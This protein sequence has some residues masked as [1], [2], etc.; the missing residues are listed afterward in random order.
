M[1]RPGSARRRQVEQKE[2]RAGVNHLGPRV[3]RLRG[4]TEADSRWSSRWSMR[5]ICW[6][7]QNRPL[8]GRGP[9]VDRL[10]VQFMADAPQRLHGWLRA[11]KATPTSPFI[12]INWSISYTR[13][14]YSLLSTRATLLYIKASQVPQKRDQA[15][16][17]YSCAFSDSALWESLRQRV[18]YL[19]WSFERGV[20]SPIHCKARKSPLSLWLALRRLRSFV[21]KEEGKLTGLG[22]LSLV[23]SSTGIRF[24]VNWTSVK[25]ITRVT[26]LYCLRFVCLLAL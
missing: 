9:R 26:C 13:V 1:W 8:E 4:V 3:D 12:E 22:H 11:I 7:C 24:L 2:F 19:L 25:Q 20:L 10:P 5:H 21:D 17:S 18:C 15:W 14:G 16:K 23:D 6:R